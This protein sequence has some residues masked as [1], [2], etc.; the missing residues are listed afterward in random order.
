MNPFLMSA[1]PGPFPN[2]SSIKYDR[3]MSSLTQISDLSLSEEFDNPGK[4]NGQNGRSFAL[5]RNPLSPSYDIEKFSS[6]WNVSQKGSL[7]PMYIKLTRIDSQRKGNPHWRPMA[8]LD[9]PP[10]KIIRSVSI[11]K[12][13]EQFTSSKI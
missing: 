6:R 13:I 4:D 2:L 9:V 11:E 5:D 3:R 8:S 1:P 10:L 12:S 7:P